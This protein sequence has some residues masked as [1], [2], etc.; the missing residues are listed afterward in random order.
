VSLAD[1]LGRVQQIQSTLNQLEGLTSA[2]GTAA[3]ASA[4]GSADSAAAF[5]QALSAAGGT[6]AVDGPGTAAGATP[7]TGA[8]TNATADALIA[9]A[10]DYVGLPYVWGGTDPAVGLDCSS[11][12]QRAFRDVGIELPRVTWDQMKEGTEVASL[13]EAQP[14]DLI[15]S[16]D[17]GH[18]SIYLG[19][20]KAIDAPQPGDTIQ[21][22]G[23]WENDGNITTIRRVLPDDGGTASAA[24]AASTAS[25]AAL[26]GSYGTSGAAGSGGAGLA[27]LVAA[28][29]ASL[30]TGG[31]A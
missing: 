2:Q 29:Q 15:F 28:A 24:N 22:R 1:M 4:A 10:K 6:G 25:L 18:V 12:V 19:N 11:F 5:A 26:A 20:G 3:T 16:H 9:A 17:G 21:V 13:A 27:D 14:G 31:V 23:L 7:S 8:G 30:V